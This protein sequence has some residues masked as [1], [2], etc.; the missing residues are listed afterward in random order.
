MTGSHPVQLF[1]KVS[2]QV[3]WLLFLLLKSYFS[4]SFILVTNTCLFL[5]VAIVSNV[6]LFSCRIEGVTITII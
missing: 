2:V 6:S 4:L 1:F 5:D 3:K